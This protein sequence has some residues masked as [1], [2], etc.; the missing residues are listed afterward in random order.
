MTRI[1]IKPVTA[2]RVSMNFRGVRKYKTRATH[3]G[4]VKTLAWWMIFSKYERYARDISEDD[5]LFDV[6]FKVLTRR[7]LCDCRDDEYGSSECP[8]HDK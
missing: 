5:G 8:I 4:A 1:G 7:L 3:T 2:Y 6:A